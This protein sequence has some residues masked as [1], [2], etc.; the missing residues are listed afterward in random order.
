[1]CLSI[2]FVTALKRNNMLWISFT[3]MIGLTCISTCV[4]EHQHG[5]VFYMAFISLFMFTNTPKEKINEI[6]E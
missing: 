6:V 1:L 2:P 4:L 3:I 5:L